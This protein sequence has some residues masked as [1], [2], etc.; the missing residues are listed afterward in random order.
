MKTFVKVSVTKFYNVPE[1]S[2]GYLYVSTDGYVTH[3]KLDYAEAHRQ[4]LKLYQQLRKRPE[5]ENNMYEPMITTRS[6]SG[7]INRE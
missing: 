1:C 3:V 5:M 7:F 6:L 4:L 2:Y